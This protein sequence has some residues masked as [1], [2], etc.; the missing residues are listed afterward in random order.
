M[1]YVAAPAQTQPLQPEPQSI[2]LR[3][4]A[5]RALPAFAAL[6]APV[7]FPDVR[8]LVARALKSAKA[9]G[10]DDLT[11]TRAAAQAVVAV[12]PDLTLNQAFNAVVQMRALGTV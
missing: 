4:D 6:A 8:G 12:R 2:A 7:G 9:M 1:T 11:Q 3:A 10:R 5:G